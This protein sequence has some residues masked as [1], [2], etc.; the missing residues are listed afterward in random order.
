MPNLDEP[1]AADNSNEPYLPYYEHLLR[2]RNSELPQ[3]ISNSYGDDE[4]VSR[5]LL[6][7]LT[8]T[9]ITDSFSQT[10]P[11]KYARR[12]CNLIGILGLRG[13]SVLESS[14]DTGTSIFTQ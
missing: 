9:C 7:N 6:P 13:I 11:L 4:Q 8:V 12:V 2:K 10:V 1:L 5:S 14:G 3:V